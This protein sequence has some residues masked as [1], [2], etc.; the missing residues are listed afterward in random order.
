MGMVEPC[1]CLGISGSCTLL[2]CADEFP[3]LSITAKKLLYLYHN[4]TCRVDTGAGSSDSANKTSSLTLPANLYGLCNQSGS[5]SLLYLDESPN[6]CIRNE[7]VGSLGTVGRECDPHSSGPNS[8]D[9]LC[10]QCG[11]QHRSYM[12]TLKQSCNCRF[13]Y[14]CQI[15]CNLCPSTRSAFVCS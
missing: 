15:Y 13:R 9:K 1:K 11:R 12:Y 4:C 8:C 2:S 6:Y 3:D 10:R 5:D 14:C 7:A